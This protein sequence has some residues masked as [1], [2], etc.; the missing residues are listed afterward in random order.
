MFSLFPLLLALVAAGSFFL[1][2]NVVYRE[3]VRLVSNAIPVS[4]SL[5]E[6]NVEQVLEQRGTVG[7]MGLLAL[8]WSA[9]GVFTSLARNINRAWPEAEQRNVFEGRLV[10]VG[11]IAVLGFLLLL[12][13]TSTAAL[14]VLPRLAIPWVTRSLLEQAF[15]WQTVG[16]LVPALFSF[17]LFL[18]MYRWVPNAGVTW[19]QAFW[20]ALAAAT[21]WEIAKRASAWY[22]ETGL[23]SYRLVYG[24]L[25]TVVAL[26]FWLYLSAWIALF[27]AHVSA[28]VGRKD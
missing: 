12:S 18:A 21:G 17:L 25:G 24:S 27:G 22:L 28:A 14:K 26:M 2:Q 9:T 20:G 8:T 5:I 4:R 13:L 15:L 7:I 11:M 23:A 19:L 6:R 3:M 1:E 10:A 16:I